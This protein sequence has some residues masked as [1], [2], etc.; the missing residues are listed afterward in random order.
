MSIP[1]LECLYCS[2]PIAAVSAYQYTCTRCRKRHTEEFGP[3]WMLLPWHTEMVASYGKFVSDTERMQ[4]AISIESV[5]GQRI[6]IEQVA[7]PCVVPR[8]R[9]VKAFRRASELHVIHGLGCRRI[10]RALVAEGMRVNVATVKRW[11]RAVKRERVD[12]CVDSM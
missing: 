7:E 6:T 12:S 5:E 10:H 9:N 3:N 1:M 4:D 8:A 11:L 2:T